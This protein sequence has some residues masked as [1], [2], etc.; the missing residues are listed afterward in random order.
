[1]RVNFS[2]NSIKMTGSIYFLLLILAFCMVNV[3]QINIAHAH[4]R[5]D[6]YLP[7]NYLRCGLEQ[8]IV[9]PYFQLP[10]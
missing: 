3:G 9:Y 2:R 8:K 4:H 6:T 7:K 5:S 1:M 10:K